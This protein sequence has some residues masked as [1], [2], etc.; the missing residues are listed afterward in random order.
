MGKLV[1]P[2]LVQCYHCRHRFEVGGRT[3][4]TACPKCHKP[5]HVSDVV[6]EKLWGP[7]RELRTCGRV[8]V[9]KKGRIIAE[10]IEA[11]DGIAVQGVLECKRVLSGDIVT[12]GKNAQWKGNL[13]A[14][15]LVIE[16]GAKIGGGVFHVPEDPLSLSDLPR[17]PR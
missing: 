3:Q 2:R 1:S 17:R 4:S 12:I 13:T 6:V 8:E 7:G 11:H 5:L 16:G 9:L 10:F 15:K 14:P